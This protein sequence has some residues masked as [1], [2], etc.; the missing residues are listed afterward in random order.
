MLNNIKNFI[1]T[2][3]IGRVFKL[4]QKEVVWKKVSEL[5]TG[6]KIAIEKNGKV[7]WDE[8][9]EIKAVGRERVYDIEVE[10]THNFVGNGIVAHNTTGKALTILNET[11]NQNVFTASASGSTIF[12][13]TRTGDTLSQ[14]YL[15]MSDPAGT[16]FLD[17]GNGG[18]SLNT[19][20]AVTVGNGTGKLTVGIID[21]AYTIDGQK[22][23]TFVPSMIGVK[24]ETTGTVTTSELV[25]GVGYRS[26]IDFG[27]QP[28]GSDIWLF[29]KA[30]DLKTNINNL[31]VLLNPSGNS[32]VWYDLDI[33]NF[34]LAI[35]SS[36]P[37]RISY[38]LTAPRFDTATWANTRTGGVT[39]FNLTPI[40]TPIPVT[41]PIATP[42]ADGLADITITPTGTESGVLYQVQNSL[43]QLIY[44]VGIFS[45]AAIANLTAGV[46]DAQ[47]I[48]SPIAQV[49]EVKTNIIS[50]LS[51]ASA[52]I[53]LKLGSNQ[54]FGITNSAGT[55]SA[56]FDSIGNA[57]IAGTLQ[58]NSLIVSQ[59]T[60]FGG[61]IS[62]TEGVS[63]IADQESMV[64]NAGFELVSPNSSIPDA[65]SCTNTGTSTG[66]CSRDTTN[67]VQGSAA[68]A[69]AKTNTANTLQFYSTCFP[70]STGTTYNVNAM[71]RGSVTLNSGTFQLGLWDF[72]TKSDCQTFTSG[73]AHLTSRNTST[74]YTVKTSSQTIDSG[75]TWARAGGI[76]NGI[77][78]TAYVDSFRVTPASLTSS[79]DIAENYFASVPLPAGT[80]VAISS[81]NDSAVEKATASAALIGIVS[82]NPALT[83]GS[84][85]ADETMLTPVAISGRVP[86]IVSSENGTIS[87]GDAVTSSTLPGVG[88]KA[89]NAGMTVGKALE[90][91]APADASCS[92]AT[93][94]DSIVWPEDDGTN[95]AKP[96]FRLPDGTYVGKIMTFVNVTWFAPA[97]TDET[98]T[99]TL[100]ADRIIS[101]FGSFDEVKTTTVSATYITNVTNIFNATPTPDASPS[102]NI[103]I[104]KD[105]TITSSLGV[106]GMTTLGATTIS[107]SLM[108]DGSL[109]LT[110]T[111]IESAGDTLYLNKGKLADVNIM[112]GALVIDTM[113][114]VAIAGDLTVSGVLGANTIS[115]LGDGNLTVNLTSSFG[116]LIISDADNMPVAAVNASGSATFSGELT[117]AKLNIA[118]ASAAGATESGNLTGNE[119]IGTGTLP[120]RQTQVTISTTKVTSNSFIYL[121]PIT[122]PDNH[123]LY[124]ISKNPGIGFTVGI[125]TSYNQN[126]DFNWWIVN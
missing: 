64:A 45:Q 115:P 29:S 69:V 86:V 94:A 15:D 104:D 83:L 58:T 48:V 14:R 43:A 75:T 87:N 114:N 91:F 52:G 39:G 121:T 63:G 111:R 56:T 47:K 59:T 123:V 30:T 10:G 53:A 37:S 89:I 19:L 61:D 105:V 119:T 2:H 17:L 120:A 95:T 109:L 7:E 84:G 116:Q 42:S 54:T 107:D 79:V 28:V 51:T 99:K 1:D 71:A 73:T 21:P 18:T 60:T 113:G 72:A 108:V 8:V 103:Q 96:C 117:A 98:H 92:A 100:Y 40:I 26:I 46:V 24:E 112:D 124:V 6:V 25:P 101:K 125:N 5:K 36:L 9:A 22:Y 106:L 20:G 85:I 50:P 126:L 74:A 55:P 4:G 70:V 62:Q 88:A 23:A 11:G 82:T 67:F 80:L 66:S 90:P 76:V 27:N 49:S 65:W 93:S 77:A 68:L 102:A 81:A 3:P 78:G 122:N 32:R 34:K 31:V 12:T 97:V 110:D 35:Y 44:N 38:R 57:T 33:P 13:V 41:G 16:Y 118:D